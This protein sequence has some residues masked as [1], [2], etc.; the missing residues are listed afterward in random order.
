MPFPHTIHWLGP[1]AQMPDA[2]HISFIGL[3]LSSILC[4]KPA[5]KWV[6]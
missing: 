1:K 6:S 3:F 2:L 5:S 4:N